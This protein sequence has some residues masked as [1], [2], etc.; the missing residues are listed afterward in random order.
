MGHCWASV[1]REEEPVDGLLGALRLDE[2]PCGV[3]ADETA[4]VLR[5]G[6]GVHERPKAHSLHHAGHADRDAK[7]LVVGH[8]AGGDW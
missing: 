8:N 4:D 6:D 7:W 2:H 5:G 3:V 1:D